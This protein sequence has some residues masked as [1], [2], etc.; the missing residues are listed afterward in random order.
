MALKQIII[1]GNKHDREDD[2]RVSRL[3]IKQF[4]E[5]MECDYIEVSVLEDKGI[6]ELL[7]M[8]IKKSM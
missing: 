8:V 4:C 7:Q 1:A 3:E 5:S 2:R 6:D